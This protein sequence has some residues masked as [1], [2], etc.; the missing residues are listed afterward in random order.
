MPTTIH[1]PNAHAATCVNC[2]GRVAA[3]AGWLVRTDDHR[4]AAAHQP[5][6]PDKPVVA[7]HPVLRANRPGIYRDDDGTVYNVRATARGQLYAEHDDDRPAPGIV[8]RLRADQ[9]ISDL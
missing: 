3:D 6:C 9:R 1:K 8:H 4:W 7:A 5:A 2:G